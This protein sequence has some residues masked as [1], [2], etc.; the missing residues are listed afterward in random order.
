MFVCPRAIL[1]YPTKESI[2]LGLSDLAALDMVSLATLVGV[3]PIL[4]TRCPIRR[5]GLSETESNG[6]V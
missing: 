5:S 4:A 3:T 1:V 2:A 6:R